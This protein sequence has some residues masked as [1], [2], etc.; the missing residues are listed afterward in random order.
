MHADRKPRLQDPF[1]PQ[2][3]S[4]NQQIKTITLNFT[5]INKPRSCQI[6]NQS[7]SHVLFSKQELD[8]LHIMLPHT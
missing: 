4:D 1:P 3:I 2:K 6:C 5:Y 7:W 8:E